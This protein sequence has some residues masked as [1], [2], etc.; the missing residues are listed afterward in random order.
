MNWMHVH[1][2]TLLLSITG[3]LSVKYALLFMVHIIVLFN[4]VLMMWFTVCPSLCGI[5]RSFCMTHTRDFSRLILYRKT[6]MDE[7]SRALLHIID[8]PCCLLVWFD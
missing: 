6:A 3:P 4:F 8:W 2:Q 1:A 7:W 5:T